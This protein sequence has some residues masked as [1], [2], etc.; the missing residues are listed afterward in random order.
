MFYLST[1]NNGLSDLRREM[2]RVFDDFWSS[3]LSSA[4]ETTTSWSPRTDVDETEDHYMVSLELPGMK[5]DELKIEVVD[6]QVVISGERKQ[7]EKS[8]QR[9]SLYSE[10]RYG[11]FQRVFSLPAH[12][13]TSKIEAQY[14]DGILNVYVPKS[15]AAKPRQIKIGDPSAGNIFSRLLGKKEDP[16]KTIDHQSGEKVA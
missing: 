5:R 1:R 10:R 6:N 12:V 4:Q 11:K 15:E 9:G 14:Q 13:D 8:R 16:A 2:D 7:E 3:P